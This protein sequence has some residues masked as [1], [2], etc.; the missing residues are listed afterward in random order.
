MP[1]TWTQ[2]K[3]TQKTVHRGSILNGD[4]L[5]LRMSWGWVRWLSPRLSSN[6]QWVMVLSQSEFVFS[7]FYG[8]SENFISFTG[9]ENKE[10]WAL[11]NTACLCQDLASNTSFAPVFQNCIHYADFPLPNMIMFVITTKITWKKF[12]AFIQ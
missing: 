6:Q 5:I 7:L 10:L 9:T 1:N 3:F 2:G 11:G 12:I 8:H 4:V